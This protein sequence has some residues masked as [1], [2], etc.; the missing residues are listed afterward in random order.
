MYEIHY[1]FYSKSLGI[2]MSEEWSTSQAASSPVQQPLQNI[3][4]VYYNHATV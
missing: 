4:L 2:S 1:N 3:L